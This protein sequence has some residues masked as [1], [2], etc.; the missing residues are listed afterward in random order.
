M[1]V[2]ANYGGATTLYAE[3]LGRKAATM[4]WIR[5]ASYDSLL[6]ACACRGGLVRNA[7]DTMV[8]HRIAVNEVT[9]GVALAEQ[10]DHSCKV[11]LDLTGQ[12]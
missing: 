11:L 7:A 6:K 1:I 5:G 9:R 2:V 3:A 8:S 10:A 12:P 4:V